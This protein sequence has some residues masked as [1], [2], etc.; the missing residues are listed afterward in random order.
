MMDPGSPT[1]T[2]H[3]WLPSGLWLVLSTIWGMLLALSVHGCRRSLRRWMR[4]RR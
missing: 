3:I 4:R 2:L 1:L